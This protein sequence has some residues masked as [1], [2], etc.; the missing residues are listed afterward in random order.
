MYIAEHPLCVKCLEEGHVVATQ[1]IH[2]IKALADGGTHLD[3]NLLALCKM[4]HSQI[5]IK[6]QG[7][8]ATRI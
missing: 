3:S 4:H 5:T 1:E 6:E 2:H 7:M 8:N